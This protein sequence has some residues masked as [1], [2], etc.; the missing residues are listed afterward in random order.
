MICI[1]LKQKNSSTLLK[2]IKKAQK[3]ADLIEIW[4]DELV[5]L[6]AKNKQK[7][8]ASNKKPI[9]YKAAGNLTKIKD[10]LSSKIG[11]IDLDI[12]TDAKII[13]YIR[14]NYPKTKIIISFHDFKKTPDSKILHSIS[15]KIIKKGADIVKIAT[16]AK[17]PEDSFRVLEFLSKLSQKKTAICLCMGKY[18]LIT[19]TSG[20]LFGN[21][22]MYAPLVLK[23]KTADG[24]ITAKELSEIQNLIPKLCH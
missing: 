8:F 10:I 3:P 6:D 20:H 2:E 16:Y 12:T 4:F 23:D 13:A 21:Y 22:L 9:I 24:Q 15:S 1:P 5:D 19:R 14:K 17:S 7:I 11:F 18:G